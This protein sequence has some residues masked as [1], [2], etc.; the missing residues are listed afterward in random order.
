MLD[1]STVPTC[2]LFFLLDFISFDSV[3][4]YIISFDLPSGSPILSL[5][6]DLLS[7]LSIQSLNL[8]IL[9][10]SFRIFICLFLFPGL[11]LPTSVNLAFRSMSTLSV[12]LFFFFNKFIYLF[13]AA[14]GLCCCVRAFL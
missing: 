5:S 2:L 13:L 9:F 3:S 14:L 10:I 6:L 11:P 4:V 1:L 7:K 8:I 12:F